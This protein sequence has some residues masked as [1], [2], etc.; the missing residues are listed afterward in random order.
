[1]TVPVSTWVG[2]TSEG[3]EETRE[4]CFYLGKEHQENPPKP[5]NEKVFI[6]ER[7]AITIFTR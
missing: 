7:P 5:T 6:T 3:A 4:M 1:M 2:M